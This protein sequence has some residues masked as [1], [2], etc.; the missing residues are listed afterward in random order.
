MNYVKTAMLL[1]FLTALFMAVGYLL[2]GGSGMMIAL[3]VASA[4]AWYSV[5]S[6]FMSSQPVIRRFGRAQHWIER[7]AGVC[8]VAIGGRILADARNPVAP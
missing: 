7:A 1:A 5:V 6:L 4:L 2:G 8:F 3:V